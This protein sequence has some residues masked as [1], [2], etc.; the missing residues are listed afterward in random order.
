MPHPEGWSSEDGRWGRS[1]VFHAREGFA[2]RELCW[3]CHFSNDRPFERPASRAGFL[4]TS[5]GC[6]CHGAFGPMHG[7]EAWIAEHGLQA[8]GRKTGELAECYMCHDGR[9]FC[10]MCHEPSMKERYNP[11]NGP[12]N[13]RRDEPRPE[14]Y[15]DY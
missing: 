11:R 6:T 5:D 14:G 15:W 12:D 8:T 10:D 2:D 1:G 3:R 13:Y 4:S 7:G 9:Y